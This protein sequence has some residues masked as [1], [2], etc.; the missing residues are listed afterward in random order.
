MFAFVTIPAIN[1]AKLKDLF[2]G[3]QFLVLLDIFSG[4]TLVNFSILAIG[5][6]PYINASIAIQLMSMVYPPLEALSKEG[7]FGRF[8]LN[9]Y[10]RFIA[11]PIAFLQSI[12]M[13]FFLKNQGI[14]G[15]LGFLELL[16]FSLSLTAGTFILMWLGE[17]ISEFGVGNGVSFII[18][19]GIVGRIP[20]MLWQSVTT[21]SQESFIPSLILILISFGVVLAVVILNE[22]Q[23]KIP[24]YYAKRIRGGKM[25][26]GSTNYLPIKLSQAGVIPIIFAVSF[27]LFPQLIGNFLASS[28]N[29]ALAGIGQFLVSVFNTQ[30]AIYNVIYFFLVVLFTFFY[31]SVVFNPQKITDEIQKYGGFIPGIRPGKN[32]RDYLQAVLYRITFIGAIFLGTIAVLPNILSTITGQQMIFFGGTSILIVVSVILETY[33][34]VQA[35]LFSHSYDKLQSSL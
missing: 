29:S 3:N 20:V 14:I 13:F 12:G 1:L 2:A 18:L 28:N 10:T 22:A 27:V 5:L 17:L 15:N 34:V 21:I 8:K 9:Q 30:G 31:S 19:A 11:L 25:Y 35:Q 7:E 4:G 32:T 23:R 6:N 33:K 26:G 16:A 24:V